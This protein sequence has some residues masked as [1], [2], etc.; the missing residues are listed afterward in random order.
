MMDMGRERIADLYQRG[1]AHNIA[2]GVPLDKLAVEILGKTTG[3][4]GGRGG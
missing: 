4:C 1:H 3:S 2:N